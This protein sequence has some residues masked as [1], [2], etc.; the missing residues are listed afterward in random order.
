MEAVPQRQK[1]QCCTLGNME[2]AKETQPLEHI[3]KN[4][5]IFGYCLLIIE[6]KD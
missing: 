5:F 4:M 1:Q 2:V 6:I 3:P